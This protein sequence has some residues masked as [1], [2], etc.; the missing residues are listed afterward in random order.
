MSRAM[1]DAIEYCDNC[2]ANVM[3]HMERKCMREVSTSDLSEVDYE[4]HMRE[5]TA[6]SSGHWCFVSHA[7]TEEKIR[8]LFPAVQ[9][10]NKTAEWRILKV[11]TEIVFSNNQ[12]KERR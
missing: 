4:I 1:G 7:K 9:V 2:D 8:E 11:T 5:N 12:R 3:C 10:I 6:S